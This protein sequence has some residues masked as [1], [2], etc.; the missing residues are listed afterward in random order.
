[1]CRKIIGTLNSLHILDFDLRPRAFFGRPEKH[2]G[3]PTE[4]FG[5][6]W[7]PFGRPFMRKSSSK[8]MSSSL[9]KRPRFV[10]GFAVVVGDGDAI[11]G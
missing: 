5:R 3:R 11:S 6:P 10:V 4:C 7:I 9:C 2:F 1:M 8:G